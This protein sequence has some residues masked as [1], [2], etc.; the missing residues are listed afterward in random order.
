MVVAVATYMDHNSIT[1]KAIYWIFFGMLN[2]LSLPS[3]TQV[4]INDSAEKS[5]TL[6]SD[7]VLGHHIECYGLC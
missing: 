6:L 2:T 3:L 4:I 5:Q 7:Y 1:A